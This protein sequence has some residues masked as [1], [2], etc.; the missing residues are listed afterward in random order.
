MLALQDFPAKE[1]ARLAT[2]LMFRWIHGVE[3]QGVGTV[4][5]LI[6]AW[7][8]SEVVHSISNIFFVSVAHPPLLLLS[9][10]WNLR[11][12]GRAFPDIETICDCKPSRSRGV[13]RQWLI[14]HTAKPGMAAQNVQVK[15]T[16]SRCRSTWHVNNNLTSGTIREADGR[17]TVEHAL[18][19]R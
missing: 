5:S 4:Q 14:D 2:S 1:C 17:F 8:K 7:S 6:A 19:H 15:L 16:C 10:P 12:L 18:L 11:P 9:S 13:S 3:A